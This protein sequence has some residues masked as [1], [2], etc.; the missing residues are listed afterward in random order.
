MNPV[1]RRTLAQMAL[2]IETQ[3]IAEAQ[4]TLDAARRGRN[5]AVARLYDE[6][7]MNC[8]E[9]AEMQEGLSRQRVSQLVAL[10]REH[11][12]QLEQEA[13]VSV[14]FDAGGAQDPAD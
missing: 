11:L 3:K 6:C 1:T 10:G 5:I 14:G 4:A 8:T 12:A 13:L 9:I 7:G 2:A